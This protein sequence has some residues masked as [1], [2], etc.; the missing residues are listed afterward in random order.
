MALFLEYR[1]RS[2][3]SKYKNKDRNNSSQEKDKNF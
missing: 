3:Y 1:T 2:F